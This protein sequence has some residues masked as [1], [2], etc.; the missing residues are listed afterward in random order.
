[1]LI[2]QQY[3]SGC[4]ACAWCEISLV[5]VVII[6]LETIIFIELFSDSAQV[7]DLTFISIQI[8]NWVMQRVFL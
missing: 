2:H 4:I 3:Q 5:P 1:V 6:V 8:L 7:K